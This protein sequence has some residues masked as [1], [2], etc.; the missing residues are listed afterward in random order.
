MKQNSTQILEFLDKQ[1]IKDNFGNLVSQNPDHTYSDRTISESFQQFLEINDILR[2]NVENGAFE[3][4]SF[5]K[6]NQILSY[7]QSIESQ[8]S[9]VNQTIVNVDTLF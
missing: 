3:K 6:R 7:L 9:N 2:V 1:T 8:I 4:I 5:N